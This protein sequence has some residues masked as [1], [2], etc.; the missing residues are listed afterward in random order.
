[1]PTRRPSAALTESPTPGPLRRKLE[2]LLF[3]GDDPWPRQ[4]HS[5]ANS[6]PKHNHYVA[7]RTAD[8]PPLIW[9]TAAFR[10]W[11]RTPPFEYE[12]HTIGVDPA[13]QGRGIGRRLLDELLSV[14]AGAVDPPG[15]PHR[16]RNG[17]RVVPQRGIHR[18]GPAP[19]VL[20]GQRRRRVH[21]AEVGFMTS[22]ATRVDDDAVGAPP[23]CGG[24]SDVEERRL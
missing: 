1:M 22:G 12:V 16:Q 4:P 9:P 14:A 3:P 18:R 19:T 21:H 10:G 6:P 11:R 17:D 5:S 2:A 7:A 24:R 23:A 15:G 20:P 13:Y 8:T